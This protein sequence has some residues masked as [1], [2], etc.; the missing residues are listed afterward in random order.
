[1]DQDKQRASEPR[2]IPGGSRRDNQQTSQTHA[3]LRTDLVYFGESII[4]CDE[5]IELDPKD[6]RAR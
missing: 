3:I 6:A 4:S 1:M 5:A 2:I